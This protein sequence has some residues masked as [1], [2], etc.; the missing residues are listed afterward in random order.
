[1]AASVL[2]YKSPIGCC[3]EFKPAVNLIICTLPDFKF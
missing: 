1:M 2:F 3:Y